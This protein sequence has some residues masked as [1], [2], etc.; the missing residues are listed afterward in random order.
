[1]LDI[2][3]KMLEDFKLRVKKQEIFVEFT[4]EAKEFI[5]D[6][7]IDSQYGARPLR[8]AITKYVEDIISE[9]ILSGNISFNDKIE[10]IVKDDNIIYVKK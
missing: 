4:K 7:S 1:M 6:K 9:E 3:D 5:L 10:A 8:R 2:L